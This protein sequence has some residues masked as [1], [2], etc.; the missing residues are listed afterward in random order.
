MQRLSLPFL[1]ALILVS[2]ALGAHAQTAPA[3]QSQEPATAEPLEGPAA[4]AP[5]EAGPANG[6]QNAAPQMHRIHP[7][8]TNRTV[9]VRVDEII[10]AD[11]NEGIDQRLIPLRL[12]L[13]SLFPSFS[14]Y[15]L[16][17]RQVGR[18]HCGRMLAFSLPGGWIVH[19]E[20]NA[21][22]DDMIAM[23]LL[24]FE[25]AR[26]LMTTQLKLRNHGTLIV[27]G[28]HYRQG[29]LIIPIGADVP[30]L[31]I[32]QIPLPGAPTA[33]PTPLP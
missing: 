6:P 7:Q 30:G 24:L 10:A 11:T 26:P 15:R 3:T 8:I 4:Q 22:E 17:S 31:P 9:M 5:E 13:H 27:G 18:T 12:R 16:I 23:H 19:V 1:T 14:T 2:F 33:G 28:P 29:M 32:P 21:I 20:P 25:G